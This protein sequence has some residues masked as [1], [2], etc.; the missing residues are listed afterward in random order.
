[1]IISHF[2]TFQL[3]TRVF[4]QSVS[5]CR[6]ITIYEVR[7]W[8]RSEKGSG[9]KFYTYRNRLVSHGHTLFGK[10]GKG[11]VSFVIAACCTGISFTPIA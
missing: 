7:S 3:N 5:E 2:P 9:D 8:A 10:R 11:L 4:N 6:Y 1:M